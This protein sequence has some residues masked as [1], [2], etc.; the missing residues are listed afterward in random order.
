MKLKRLRH[1]NKIVINYF[2]QLT[3]SGRNTTML[4]LLDN[5]KNPLKIVKGVSLI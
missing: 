5:E 2:V 3:K 4:L 1:N